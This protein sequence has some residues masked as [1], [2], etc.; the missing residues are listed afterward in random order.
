MKRI[1]RFG[2]S[3]AV[4]GLG[5]IG[6]HSNSFN[7]AAGLSGGFGHVKEHANITRRGL[8]CAGGLHIESYQGLFARLTILGIHC[9]KIGRCNSASI[10]TIAYDALRAG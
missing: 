3:L 9:N 10:Q 2:S 4:W 5:E 8:A 7:L 6:F 1:R